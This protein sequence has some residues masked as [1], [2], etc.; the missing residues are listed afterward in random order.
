LIVR[1]GALARADHRQQGVG[2]RLAHLGQGQQQPV[3]RLTR[4]QVADEQHQRRPLWQPKPRP[5]LGL[6]ARAEALGVHPGADHPHPGGVGAQLDRLG[7]DVRADRDQ[8][9]G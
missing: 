1:A 8:P 2:Q 9:I 7:G 3:D 6:V 4:L 5:R